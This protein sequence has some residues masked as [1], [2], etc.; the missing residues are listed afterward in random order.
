[1]YGFAIFTG[2]V[3]GTI[4]QAI[5]FII[6]SR[7]L[8]IFAAVILLVLQMASAGGL[9]PIETQAK[10]YQVLNMLLPMGHTVRIYRELAFETR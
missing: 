5:R 1:M 9:F 4:V 2:I 10:G 3:F 8:G 6:P 7:N